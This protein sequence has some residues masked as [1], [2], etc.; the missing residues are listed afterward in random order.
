MSGEM[1]W[2]LTN[3]QGIWRLLLNVRE[4]SGHF[5]NCQGILGLLL[6]VREFSQPSGNFGIVAKCPGILP[7]VREF[8]DCC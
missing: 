1:S 5:T 3:S 6:N 4:M 8:W 2:S 7:T